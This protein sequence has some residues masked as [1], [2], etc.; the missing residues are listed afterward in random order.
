MSERRYNQ[1]ADMMDKWF[2]EEGAN[3]F[4][5]ENKELF[6][7]L[8]DAKTPGEEDRIIK[9]I[10]AGPM[11]EKVLGSNLSAE[12]YDEVVK[13]FPIYDDAKELGDWKKLKS[14]SKAIFDNDKPL[15]LTDTQIDAWARK[16]GVKPEY[17]KTYI[18]NQFLK[19]QKQLQFDTEEKLKEEAAKQRASD[20]TKL[21]IVPEVILGTF[22]P[23]LK[24]RLENAIKTGEG[25]TSFKELLTDGESLKAIGKD[26]AYNASDIALT[27][28]LGKVARGIK[29]A[30]S[31]ARGLTTV[32][33]EAV[34]QGVLEAG[35]EAASDYEDMSLKNIG[36]AAGA[37]LGTSGLIQGGLA[38]AARFMPQNAEMIEKINRALNG[39]EVSG[40]TKDIDAWKNANKVSKGLQDEFEEVA[41]GT[42]SM[43]PGYEQK[44]IN[45]MMKTVG[46]PQWKY[47]QTLADAVDGNGNLIA[48]KT[49]KKGK[50]LSDEERRNI[51]LAYIEANQG[52]PKVLSDIRILDV[53]KVAEKAADVKSYR[54]LPGYPDMESKMF[55]ESYVPLIEIPH[56]GGIA[57]D[58]ESKIADQRLWR[59]GTKADRMGIVVP[60]VIGSGAA[61]VDQFA[62]RYLAKAPGVKKR[63]ETQDQKYQR[64]QKGF[65]TVEE[66]QSPEYANFKAQNLKAILGLE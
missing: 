60:K 44:V 46:S 31:V 8:N 54:N 56:T 4:I 55:E 10:N 61:L 66:M 35:R 64:W 45:D 38:G 2:S 29:G 18:N 63:E 25:P 50:L 1:Y 17:L 26:I 19:S 53:D 12:D 65:Q 59:G 28:G 6:K 42:T 40:T 62:P 32:G 49:S 23:E 43:T 16:E 21:G 15:Q 13:D 39:K 27:G 57:A 9:E 52:N 33:G 58:V 20:A 30:G 47:S 41:K 51:V 5:V 7:R 37:G 36:V 14:D 22:A 3:K 24:N 34:K 48:P 11:R